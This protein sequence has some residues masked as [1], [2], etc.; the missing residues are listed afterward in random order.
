MA[1]NGI[2]Y[3]M[4]ISDGMADRPLPELDG[5]TPMQ[6]AKKP[7]MDFLAANGRVGAVNT[8]PEGMDP[9]SDVAAMSLLG[10]NPQEYY[11]GRAPI[12]AASMRIPLGKHDVAFRCNLVSTDGETMLDYSGGHV[13]TEEARELITC[14]NQKLGTQQIRFYPGISYRHI[15]VWSGGSPN[16]KTVPPH[17]FTGKPLSPNLPEGDGDAKLK[18]LIFDSLEILDSHPIN[19]RRRDEGKLPA[20]MIWLWG[21]GFSLCLP[22]FTAKTGHTGA[23]IAAVDLVKGLGIAAGLTAPAVPGVTGY[24]DT[25]FEGKAKYALEAL[26]TR[27]FVVVHVEAPDEAGHNGDIDAKI[28][29]IENVD[30][31]TLGVLMEGLRGVER[32]RILVTPDHATPIAIRTHASEPIPFTIYSSFESSKSALPFD[33]RAIPETGLC[34]EEGFRLID[35]LFK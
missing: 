9:G 17:N 1:E 6:V 13:S 7:N 18:S 3:I 15:M 12:E 22:N 19:R 10:Y 31:R 28:Q 27:D 29:A 14:V 20:N 5:K 24:L 33:E 2:K 26:K 30:R 25:N 8:I 34:I 21:Q 35:L 23:V 32:F 11:T 4:L 16:V